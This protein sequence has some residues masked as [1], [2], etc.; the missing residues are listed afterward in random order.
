MD[1][2]DTPHEAPRGLGTTQMDLPQPPVVPQSPSVSGT[3]PRRGRS[4]IG[5]AVAATMLLVAVASTWTLSSK[6]SS[7]R[8]SV[9][10]QAAEIEGLEDDLASLTD[11]IAALNDEAGRLK[12]EGADLRAAIGDCRDAAAGGR[13]MLAW[14]AKVGMGRASLSE[15]KGEFRDY[16]KELQV[17]T[18]QANS[19]GVF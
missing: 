16:R 4:W 8:A 2:L 12:D 14:F 5:W 10:S 9:E 15:A 11:D 1:T 13:R 7:E 19:N 3:T 18:S 17:C 6:L